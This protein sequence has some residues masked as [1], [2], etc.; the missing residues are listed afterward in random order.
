MTR[1]QKPKNDDP[2]EF[3]RFLETAKAVEASEDP[4]DFERAF[5]RVAPPLTRRAKRTSD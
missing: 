1:K 3:K 2:A 5:K 4:E